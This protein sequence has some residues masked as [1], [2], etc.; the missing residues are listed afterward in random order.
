M[1]KVSPKDLYTVS[2]KDL[3]AVS[4]KDLYAVSPKDLYA[5]SPKDL[6]TVSPESSVTRE[7]LKK[8]LFV[9]SFSWDR[10]QESA[11]DYLFVC[12]VVLIPCKQSKVK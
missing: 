1:Y 8:I 9:Y 3:Y 7:H 6:Y 2:P 10:I 4:P 5:V 11:V 12:I